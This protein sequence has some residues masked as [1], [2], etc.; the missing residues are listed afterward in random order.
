MIL[1]HLDSVFEYGFDFAEEFACAKIFSVSLTP[2]IK[3][4]RAHWHRGVKLSVAIETQSRAQQI[5]QSVH[6]TAESDNFFHG[7]LLPLKR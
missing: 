6:D 7:L 4:P 5:P 1:T 3:T 2:L